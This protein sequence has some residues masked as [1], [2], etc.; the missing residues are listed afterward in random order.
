MLFV[1]APATLSGP[2]VH[3]AGGFCVVVRFV[4]ADGVPGLLPA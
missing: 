3:V 1:V 2:S 4:G